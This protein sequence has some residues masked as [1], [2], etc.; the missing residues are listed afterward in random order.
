MSIVATFWTKHCSVDIP[1]VL[2]YTHIDGRG[3]EGGCR[4]LVFCVP[5]PPPPQSGTAPLH[6]RYIHLSHKTEKQLVVDKHYNKVLL[7]THVSHRN[8]P[9]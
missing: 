4:V 2:I 8:L 6:I 1:Y 7:L 3:K 9:I 5:D